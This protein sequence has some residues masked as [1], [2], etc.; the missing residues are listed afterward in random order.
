MKAKKKVKKQHKKSWKK[1][2]VWILS[3][4][5]V[6]L[7]FTG[8][9]VIGVVDYLGYGNSSEHT[10][11]I[12]KGSST[13]E[14][15]AAL[16]EN[17]VITSKLFFRLFTKLKKYDGKFNYGVYT[18]NDDDS[19]DSI[20]LKLQKNGNSTDTVSVTIPEGAT[21]DKIADLLRKNGVC[22]R[23]E[24]IN[25]VQNSEYNYSFIDDIPKN[26]VYYRLEGYLFPDSYD[27]YTYG[28]T[29]CAEHAVN[30][31]L[32][33]YNNKVT[34]KM[35][36]KAEKMG[37]SM[38]D[39][40]TLASI[41]ELEAGSASYTDKQKVSAVFYNRLSWDEPKLL[42]S[43][44]TAEYKYGNGKYDTNVTEGLPPGPLC[45]PSVEALNAALNPAENF[46]S[47]YFVTDNKMKF[48]YTNSLAEHN[49]IIAEL[50]SKGK[51]LG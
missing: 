7:I 21:V 51:W 2:L 22:T 11:E 44:P 17:D 8:V 4:V 49:K 13:A 23:Q 38:H 14:I 12:S 18:F 37:Y 42:G 29:D 5:T 30:K 28:G 20:C 24:F 19:Y 27:F 33:N 50:K 47:T 43:S 36:S 34:D 31:M 3:I 15:A 40:T 45:S 1:S 10:V 16:K 39:I 6:S 25:A 35:R 32:T 26:E 41:I 48:Y 9:V 46:K